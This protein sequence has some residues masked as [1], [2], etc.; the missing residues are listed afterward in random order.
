MIV[1]LKCIHC[2]LI[3]LKLNEINSD[4]IAPVKIAL[5]TDIPI[6]PDIHKLL[7]KFKGKQLFSLLDMRAGYWTIPLDE[8]T[9]KLTAFEFDGNLYHWNVLPMG[10]KQAPAIFQRIM[11]KLFGHLKFV[12]V[13]LD[14]IA[15][16]SDN[17]QQHM[18][19]L[20]IVFDILRKNGIKLRVDKCIFAVPQ[21]KDELRLFLGLVAFVHQFIPK[22]LRAFN[23]IK[24]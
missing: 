16:L 8:E 18:D 12:I 4:E 2:Q 10:L 19:H 13:Y 23:M 9:K 14:D 11:N 7:H 15:I 22:C 24:N 1:L 20:R 17:V 3:V 6:T 21:D 5:R